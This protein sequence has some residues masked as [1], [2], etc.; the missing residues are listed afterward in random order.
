MPLKELREKYQASKPRVAINRAIR[1]ECPG[2]DEALDAKDYWFKIAERDGWRDHRDEPTTPAFAYA[3]ADAIVKKMEDAIRA[4]WGMP[5][6][7]A[8]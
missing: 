6:R 4:R 2:G 5:P 8:E 7:S 1:A 3:L